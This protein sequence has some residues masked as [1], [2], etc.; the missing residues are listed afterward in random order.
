M[1]MFAGHSCVIYAFRMML[2]V[3]LSWQ[4]KVDGR[5]IREIDDLW[6]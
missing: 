4:A 2:V 5:G 1:K 3:L 6:V